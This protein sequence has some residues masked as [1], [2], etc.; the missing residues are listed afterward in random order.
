MKRQFPTYLESESGVRAAAASTAHSQ[1]HLVADIK[2]GL[3]SQEFKAFIQPKIHLLDRQVAG[4]E[5]LARWNHPVRGVLP[6]GEFIPAMVQ[7]GLIDSLLWILFKQG[8][9]LQRQLTQMDA[10][11]PL[12]LN[13]H[14]MQLA[15]KKLVERLIE[16]IERNNVRH[17]SIVFEI[18]ESATLP[19]S[20]AAYENALHLRRAG[21]GLSLDDFGSGYSTLERLIVLPFTE[22]KLDRAFVQRVPD[23]FQVEAIISFALAL[24]ERLSMSMVVEGVETATQCQRLIQ[25]GVQY[26]Q[27]FF[28]ARSMPSEVFVE[29]CGKFGRGVSSARTRLF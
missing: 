29:Y 19:G 10:L 8:L 21:C 9:A 24:T 14:P 17:N 23:D 3:E 25:L 27:G 12:S 16:E 18:L 28:F 2:R 4:G 26:A 20:S 5:L 1:L 15:N 11:V 6:A 7:H 13:L 22:V